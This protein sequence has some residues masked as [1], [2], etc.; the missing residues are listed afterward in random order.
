MSEIRL[1]SLTSGGGC[2][3]KMNP[4]ALEKVLRELTPSQ[5]SENVLVGFEGKD[6][7]AAYKLN[8]DQVVVQSVDFFTPMLDHPF[9]FGEVAAANAISDIYAM[10]ADP[11]FALNVVGFPSKELPLSILQEILEGARS[12][13]EQANVVMLGGHSIEDREP[14]FGMAVTGVVHPDRLWRNSGARPGDVL[15]LTKP[16]GVGVICSAHKKEVVSDS[17]LDLR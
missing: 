5:P 8:S 9:H 2:A 17:T 12:K 10:G 15:L 7:C 11:L 6:D 16:L 1:T 14:K 3:C 4:R 13:A